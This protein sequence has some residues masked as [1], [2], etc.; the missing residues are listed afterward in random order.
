[1]LAL[2]P[3]TITLARSK[4]LTF[5]EK[6][7]SSCCVLKVMAN[8]QCASFGQHA[9]AIVILIVGSRLKNMIEVPDVNLM[10]LG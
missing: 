6:I 1:M 8:V 5:N 9:R 3:V 4:V 10:H 2:S 7:S